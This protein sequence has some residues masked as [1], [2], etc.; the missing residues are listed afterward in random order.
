MKT[1]QIGNLE[2]SGVEVRNILSLR[3]ANFKFS[4]EGDNIKF[5]GNWIWAWCWNEPNRKQIV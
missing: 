4:I 2:L 1:I 3:S 5:G